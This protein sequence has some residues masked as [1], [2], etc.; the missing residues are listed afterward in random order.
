VVVV[1]LWSVNDKATTELMTKFYEKT[2]TQS[3][4]SAAALPAA[5]GGNV[6]TKTVAVAVLLGGIHAAGR[7]AI[8]VNL[9]RCLPVL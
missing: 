2:L 1:S 9:G 3:E 4:R 8:D 5:T 6:E 7:M